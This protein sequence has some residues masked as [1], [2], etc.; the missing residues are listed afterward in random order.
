MRE[1]FFNLQKKHE[2][3]K[4]RTDEKHQYEAISIG[5]KAWDDM[6]FMFDDAAWAIAGETL[7][8]LRDTLAMAFRIATLPVVVVTAVPAVA[9]E[10]GKITVDTISEVIGDRKLD[11]EIVTKA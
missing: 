4:A 5:Y 10:I 8:P 1:V 9:C 3:E 2:A 6:L 11:T 7:D